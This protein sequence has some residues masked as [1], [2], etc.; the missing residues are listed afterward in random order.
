M[1]GGNSNRFDNT[2]FLFFKHLKITLLLTLLLVMILCKNNA[3]ER[4]NMMN[5]KPLHNRIQKMFALITILGLLFVSNTVA[6]GFAD[7]YRAK[8]PRRVKTTIKQNTKGQYEGSEKYKL[9]EHNVSGYKLKLEFLCEA[10]G[11]DLVLLNCSTF[12]LFFPL[13]PA[14][15]YI[16]KHH[17]PNLQEYSLRFF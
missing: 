4:V 13:I 17:N 6:A 15:Y 1:L 11:P 2:S 7:E 16:E 14:A 12:E 10:K 3:G 5:D 9:F 8:H